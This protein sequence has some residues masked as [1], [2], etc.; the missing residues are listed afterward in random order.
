VRFSHPEQGSALTLRE[1]A[2]LHPPD[3]QFVEPNREINRKE[4][5]VHIGNAV[6]VE[7]GVAIGVSI[8]DHVLGVNPIDRNYDH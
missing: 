8:I 5:G 7:L 4:V 2:P 1:G 3:Y 6:P